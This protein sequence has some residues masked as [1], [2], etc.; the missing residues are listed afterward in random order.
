[1]SHCSRT[2]SAVRCGF[3]R[4]TEGDDP[5]VLLDRAAAGERAEA[6]PF[7]AADLRHQPLER[8][9]D[10]AVCR[11]LDEDAVEAVVR[12]NCGVD[13]GGG[14]RVREVAVGGAHRLEVVPDEP[15]DA[16]RGRQRLQGGDDR[17]RVAR[18]ARRERRDPRVAVWLR[19]D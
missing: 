7:E 13:V 16:E 10:L 19:L 2:A 12:G 9:G 6:G 14:D 4:C 8:A 3:A 17:E 15:R 5:L 18:V 11:G 1:M